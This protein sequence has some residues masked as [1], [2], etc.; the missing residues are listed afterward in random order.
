MFVP[1]K[2]V[3]VRQFNIPARDQRAGG[4]DEIA[5]RTVTYDA[6]EQRRN[7]MTNTEE[8]T[9]RV[10]RL[11]EE[12]TKTGID[13]AAIAPTSNMRY[14]LGFSPLADERLCLVLVT[15]SATRLVVPDLNADQVEAH[16]GVEGLRWTDDEGPEKALAEALRELDAER[17]ALLAADAEMRA[18]ALLLLQEAA[19]PDRS[20]SAAD[21]MSR[22]RMRKS[23]SEIEALA[24]AAEQ[25]DRAMMAGVEACQP[26]VTEREIAQTIARYFREDGAD[27]VEFTLVASGPNGAFPHHEAGERPLEVGDTIVIDIGASLDG[28]KSDITRMVHLGEPSADVRAVHETVLEANR[29]GRKAAT[30]GARASDVDR[31]ARSVIEEAGYGQYF[32]HR[33][34]HGLG[35]DVHEAPWISADSETVL[36]PGMV[37]SVEPGIYL[38]ERFGVRIEDIVAVTEGECRCFTGLDRDLIVKR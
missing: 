21:L 19:Q 12:M 30:A 37:F 4:K 32:V 35:M 34:G 29:R 11:Q 1:Y 20:V 38:P 25:A 7:S 14:L 15:S 26:G 17:P 13:L 10:E 28:Y 36:E 16:T 31:A 23:G 27:T 6:K 8:H 5:T 9:A 2:K 22:L 3:H 33:T 18:D 24:R